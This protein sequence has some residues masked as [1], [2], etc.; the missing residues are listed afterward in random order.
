[1]PE[2][3]DPWARGLADRFP[4]GKI[5]VC[6]EQS[7]GRLIDA[8]LTYDPLVLSPITPRML[9]RFRDALAPSGKKDD[10]ADAQLWLELVSTHREKLKP[11]LPADEPTRTLPF[12]VEPR[13][14][15]V[16]DNTRLTNR[17]TSVLKGYF[18]HV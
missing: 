3:I 16:Q 17:L 9:A 4:D 13:R 1:M 18:P 7:T 5:A 14:K 2:E 15:L 6:L 8:L 11:W 12:V 10:P